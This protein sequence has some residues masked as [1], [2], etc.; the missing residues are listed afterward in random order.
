MD[1]KYQPVS[2]AIQ[3]QQPSQQHHDVKEETLSEQN[4]NENF[5]Q[6]APVPLQSTP[7]TPPTTQPQSQSPKVTVSLP[8][9]AASRLRDL[10]QRRD[11]ALL[12]L[13]IISVQFED[14]QIIPLTLSTTNSIQPKPQH[15][16]QSQQSLQQPI[17]LHPDPIMEPSIENCNPNDCIGN[18]NTTIATLAGLNSSNDPIID[19]DEDLEPNIN[20]RSNQAILGTSNTTTSAATVAHAQSIVARCKNDHTSLPAVYDDEDDDN[21]DEVVSE[22]ENQH[23]SYNIHQLSQLEFADP[24]ELEMYDNDNLLFPD[25]TLNLS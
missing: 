8:K 22:V 6:T 14:D 13:G 20:N 7:A 2:T 4:R 18:L 16:H 25:Y 5:S 10:V 24:I 17:S 1:N 15:Q 9:H 21:K 23:S 12:R 11:I 3:H 19:D